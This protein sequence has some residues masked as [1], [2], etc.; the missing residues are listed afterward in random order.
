MPGKSDDTA[1]AAPLEQEA[2]AT[3]MTW[4]VVA[5][6]TA[7]QA[8][9]SF[10][11]LALTGM[12]PAAANS[13]G[14]PAS[15]VGY[16]TS[17]VYGAAMLGTLPLGPAIARW[18]ACRVNQASLLLAAAGCALA[19]V[20]ALGV[21]AMG[22]LAMGFG[23]GSTVPAAAHLLARF[24]PRRRRNLFF[25]IKQTGVPFGG[26]L[27]GAV[28]PPIAVA[29]GWRWT[30]ACVAAAAIALAALLQVARE[31][32]DDDREPGTS[33]KINPLHGLLLLRAGPE[34][35]ALAAHG[36]FLGIVQ[37]S[38]VSFLVTLLAIEAGLDL[39]AAGLVLSAFLMTGA[40]ARVLWG[41]VA[42]RAGSGLGVL[43]LL[44]VCTTAGVL[45][46][47]TVSAG[48]SYAALMA[49]FVAL[50]V[51]AV[52]WNG[53]YLAEAARLAPAGQ[54]AAATSGSISTLYF[55]ALIGPSLFATAYGFVGSYA[56][57]FGLLG[58]AGAG[59]VAAAAVAIRAA[60]RD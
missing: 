3:A 42:D 15:Y 25:S 53:V 13:L 50:A 32:W 12:A 6:T 59:A 27:A 56:A 30:L 40:A 45:A 19:A 4:W 23:L 9:I 60:R 26:V 33:L 10:A 20:P 52:G 37:L 46:V 5:A 36:F 2:V 41:W 58:I 39:V 17:V 29:F 21:V 44:A 22:S 57:T 24:T 55:G 54:V 28:G 48:W 47:T 11:V 1:R 38:T 14:V 18:G 49:L 31:R 7:I 43:A 16:H 35:M 34:L 8:A 51:S